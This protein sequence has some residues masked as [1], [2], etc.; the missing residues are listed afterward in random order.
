MNV[1]SLLRITGIIGFIMAAITTYIYIAH[2]LLPAITPI[3]IH[4]IESR[5]SGE[6]VAISQGD[7]SGF[8]SFM[9]IVMPITTLVGMVIGWLIEAAVLMALLRAFKIN[10][11][12]TDTW[13]LSGNYFYVSVVQTAVVITTPL[14]EYSINAVAA[15]RG[16][17]GEPILLAV[18][19][20]FTVVGSLLLAYIF[21]RAYGTSITKALIPTLIA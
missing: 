21:A 17:L 7:I 10:A 6:G 15:R 20:V 12:F 3:L 8:I 18:G 19:L 14:F 1:K 5:L 2:I 4:Q 16:I 13:L 9:G 11:G